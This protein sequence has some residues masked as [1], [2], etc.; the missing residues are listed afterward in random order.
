MAQLR[1]VGKDM[2][3]AK[4][5]APA[6]APVGSP[7]GAAAS[8]VAS[9]SRSVVFNK[10]GP[11]IPL[12]EEEQS[13]K[14]DRELAEGRM[15]GVEEG[16]EAASSSSSNATL[17]AMLAKRKAEVSSL[18]FVFRDSSERLLLTS[19]LVSLFIPRLLLWASTPLSATPLRHSPR[20]TPLAAVEH[21]VAV[22]FPA[23]GAE[24]TGLHR[25]ARR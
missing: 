19:L 15:E 6:S 12:T 23:V 11:S 20:T 24:H 18:I 25:V 4:S 7:A 16:A 9:G 5:D 13:A 14:L 3:A 8:P 1:Q 21:E 2:D 10:P 22:V 17:L